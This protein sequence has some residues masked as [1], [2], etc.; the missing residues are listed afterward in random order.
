MLRTLTLLLLASSAAAQGVP[1]QATQT[2]PRATP[3][4]G[5]ALRSPANT[6]PWAMRHGDPARTGRSSF[7]GA[8]QGELDWKFRVAG[9]VPNFA[10]ARDGTVHC[11]TVFH[12]E[13][14]SNESFVYALTGAGELE[15]RAKVEPWE[16]G[17]SQGVGGSP[18]LDMQERVFVPSAHGRL[19]QFAPSGEILWSYEGYVG[20]S[21]E[22]SPA[23]LA[24]GSARHYM[25]VRGLLG[26]ANGGSQ[27]FQN[28]S[29]QTI[30]TAV[31]VAANGEMAL[32]GVRTN[33]PHGAPALYYFNADGTLRWSRS[34]TFGEESTPA[35]G[36]D[37]TVYAQY[38]GTTAF[39]PDNTILWTIGGATSRSLGRN[40]VLYLGSGSQ[41]RLHSAASGA[42]ISTIALPGAVN[43][44]LA[45]DVAGNVYAT[46]ANG[47]ACAYAANG[48]PIFERK[49]ADAFTT[50]PAIATAA[51]VV[52]AGKEGFTK[53][54]YSIR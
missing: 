3:P 41:I 19:Y 2:G 4:S 21:H 44:G 9:T 48:A 25:L 8:T 29:P 30:R 42:P 36:D 27:L 33:E 47:W 22:S 12:E 40:G 20:A 17:F 5:L 15:W 43:E 24:D 39:R 28:P 45:I 16:W 7:P 51:R 23:V 46:T 18:A 52:A 10:V 49:L 37:G 31:A 53:F 13:W 14:W 38:L 50:G 54:V 11:G 32:S 35:I 34:T 6:H 1:F 26:F